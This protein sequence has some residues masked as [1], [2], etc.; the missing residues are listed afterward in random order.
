[1]INENNMNG[2]VTTV[3]NKNDSGLIKK[4]KTYTIEII[5]KRKFAFESKI[6]FDKK[7]KVEKLK[8]SAAAV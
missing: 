6:C 5:I 1:M 2:I 7:I 4:L 3:P 8:I